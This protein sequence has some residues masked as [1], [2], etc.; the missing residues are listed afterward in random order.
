MR[1]LT[2]QKI[3]GIGILGYL[4]YYAWGLSKASTRVQVTGVSFNSLSQITITVQNFSTATVPFNG[5]SG[6]IYAQGTSIATV[7]QQPQNTSIPANGVTNLLVNINPEWI[8]L[9]GVLLKDVSNLI[10]DDNSIIQELMALAPKLKG[11]LYI[12]NFDVLVEIN[13]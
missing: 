11:N 4:A 5:F 12:N 3:F 1:K 7:T 2:A 9:G 8:A 6:N 10:G 13:F